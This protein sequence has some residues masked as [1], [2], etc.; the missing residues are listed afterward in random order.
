M[1][2]DNVRSLLRWD[3]TE[4]ADTGPGADPADI[5]TF[6]DAMGA[7]VMSMMS[8]FAGDHAGQLRR[9]ERNLLKASRDADPHRML[10]LNRQYSQLMLEQAFAM[11]VV[12]KTVQSID[13][14]AKLQ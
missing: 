5:A 1:S 8:A 9:V 3:G 4:A 14:L 12:G 7:S 2:H 13:S 6:E 10:E 11:K